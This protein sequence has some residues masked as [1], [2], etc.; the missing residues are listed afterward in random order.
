[1]T[2]QA[3]GE[4]FDDGGPAAVARPCDG[5]ARSLQH[6]QRVVAVH[7]LRGHAIGLAVRG[8]VAHHGV[9][10]HRR[11]LGIAVV[12]AHQHDRQLPQRGHVEAF[13]EAAGVGRAVAEIDGD[14][15]AFLARDQRRAERE[16]DRAADDAG[17]R[18]QPPAH[19]HDV[20]GA[21]A[22]AA[23]AGVL[24]GQFRHQQ[25]GIGAAGEEMS[26]RTVRAVE[27]V[28]LAQRRGDPDRDPF[29]A[30]SDMHE[31]RQLLPVAE[32]DHALF[33][34]ADEPH[35]L[36]HVPEQ[37][38]GIVGHGGANASSRRRTG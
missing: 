17:R 28:A 30:D 4:A 6:R 37:G 1:M 8:H 22:A 12:L 38:V 25:V 5:V 31:A 13:V 19:V 34:R 27:V 21:A 32:L 14:D 36:Q 15:V 7:D 9:G 33:E 2:A 11:E 3:V 20:H 18:H 26:V 24:A 29:L 16:R 35:P 23:K 10:R